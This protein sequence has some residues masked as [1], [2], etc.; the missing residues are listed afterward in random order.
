MGGPIYY[1]GMGVGVANFATVGKDGLF[2]DLFSALNWRSNISH[3]LLTTFTG[4][5]LTG[6]NLGL[7]V[8]SANSG[9]PLSSYTGRRLVV[10]IG[11]SGPYM[12]AWINSGSQLTLRY[13]L[14]T[15]ITSLSIAVYI[16]V[17]VGIFLLPGTDIEY[18]GDV[19]IPGF[20][21]LC[22]YPGTTRLINTG[23]SGNNSIVLASDNEI[24]LYGI[25]AT[26]YTGVAST[27]QL[28]VVNTSPN[29]SEQCNVVIDNCDLNGPS[30][31]TI[32]VGPGN[33]GGGLQISNCHITGYYDTIRL[34]SGRLVRIYNNI[35]EPIGVN[36]A[37]QA[38]VA[39]VAIGGGVVSSYPDQEVIM[40]N[41]RFHSYYD[42]LSGTYDSNPISAV[43]VRG[44]VNTGAKIV[45]S[46]NDIRARCEYASST[47]SVAAMIV[48]D[49]TDTN[50]PTLIATN[51][52]IDCSTAGTGTAYSF[53]SVNAN[54][55]IKHAGNNVMA[56][57]LGSNTAALSTV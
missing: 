57:V 46:G 39:A 18:S 47:S 37:Y 32:Y 45:L 40:A 38:E 35:I 13:P 50:T 3:E 7:R 33:F 28:I 26:Q 31:D 9:T 22:A 51:N 14:Q 5:S 49:S 53:Q 34:Y 15:A 1:E 19:T 48:T 41:N 21:T 8:I 20:T 25:S 52:N 54:Y 42:R 4:S 56:G 11:G 30:F 17:Y 6:E 24:R 44:L 36:G 10:Q 55:V 43:E 16:P 29:Y 27:A 2:P 23:E 12:H